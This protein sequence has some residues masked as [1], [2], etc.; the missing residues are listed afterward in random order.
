MR[1]IAGRI[2]QLMFQVRRLRH[3]PRYY[4]RYPCRSLAPPRGL[5][6]IS[7]G[8]PGERQQNRTTNNLSRALEFRRVGNSLASC[9]RLPRTQ[10]IRVT[11]AQNIDSLAPCG[12]RSFSGIFK[13]R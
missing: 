11:V 10:G 9:T 5:V 1:P 2:S 6:V 12:Q 3:T 4:R 13:A 7:L 8:F